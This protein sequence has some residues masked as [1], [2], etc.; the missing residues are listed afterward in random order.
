MAKKMQKIQTGRDYQTVRNSAQA[1]A[2]ELGFD[3]GI[4][5][6]AFGYR[7]FMLP[8]RENRYGHETRCEVVSPERIERSQPGHGYAT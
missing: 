7:H 6:D 4:E 2:N 5:L 1:L 3:Y 8:R